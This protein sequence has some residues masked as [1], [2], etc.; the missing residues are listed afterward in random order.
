M[1]KIELAFSSSNTTHGCKGGGSI[2]MKRLALFPLLVALGSGFA[3]ADVASPSSGGLGTRING[4]LG[5]KCS[6]G[7]CQV[8][9]GTN[10]GS[11]RFYRLSEF[12]T[13][14]Q[15]QGVSIDS[16]GVNNLVVG[17]TAPDGTFINKGLTDDCD[18]RRDR[19]AA[20]GERVSSQAERQYDPDDTRGIRRS[21][22]AFARSEENANA[23]EETPM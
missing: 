9:G 19:G 18:G 17:V 1:R 21:H 4:L 23:Q 22:R 3:H 16:N 5:G 10:S 7:V 13:R 20:E 12:D 2:E 14:G 8:D 6:S 15:I 11:N